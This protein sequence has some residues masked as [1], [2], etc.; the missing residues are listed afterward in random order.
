MEFADDRGRLAFPNQHTEWTPAPAEWE[1][2]KQRS[3]GKTAKVT[4]LGFQHDA[5]THILSRGQ[6]CIS[7]SEDEV[8]APLFYREVNLPF[9]EA[10]KDPSRIR[11]RFGAVSSTN[12]PPVMLEHLPV[13][14]N[15]H[16]FSRDG[17]VL[18]MDVDYANNKGSYVTTRVAKE[19][20]LA[21]SEIMTWDDYKRED[22]QQTLGLLSQ[23]SPDGQLVVSTVKD[24][25]VFVARPD[26]AFSQLFFPVK[27]I[28]VVYHRNGGGFKALPGADDPAYVQ[29]NPV[30]SPDGKYIVFA[31]SK[32]Y[33]LRNKGAAGK[34]LLTEEDC[35]EFLREGKP[36][37]YDLYRVPYNNGA[38]G[39]AEPLAGASR[40]GRS[41]YF[42]KYSPDGKW[43]VFCQ[44]SNYMLLQ[45]DS[46]L[47]IIPA[48]GG[49]ARRLKCN[50]SR[51]N[52][53][54]SWSPNSRW[55][56]FSSKAN[57]SYTQLFLTHIDEQGESSVPVV[58]AHFTAPDRAANIPKF[59][60][61]PA[62][63][64]GKINE[65]FLNDYSHVRAA[66][67]SE[68]SGDVDYAISEYQKALALNPNSMHAHQRL[69]YLLYN[70]KHKPEEGLAHTTEA[71]R[72]D[73]LNGFAHY[74][75]G[76]AMRG[77]GKLDLA[78]E[79]FAAAVRLTPTSTLYHS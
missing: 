54:H 36:F 45:P 53:W 29:S 9:A 4:V 72:L 55:L 57:S 48:E 17:R 71:L 39:K 11:W 2:I 65:Q 28:L 69:G 31:R 52:S 33:E 77:E 70:V 63:A 41:N 46:V 34:V 8:G 30:W 74:D 62:D 6:V 21:S 23:V 20:V 1:T 18:G 44:A 66:F 35:A 56:V 73:P 79:H 43:I 64:I 16:S 51:M 22:G 10:V 76:M 40:N 26:L 13:C 47:Y 7:T 68:L 75:L 5:P 14:G 27:G 19:M 37:T 49:E 25:S 67:F 58:L 3:R 78:A 42:P 60:N 32:A 61:A 50:M 38:G 12:P 15:C 59:V 24:K